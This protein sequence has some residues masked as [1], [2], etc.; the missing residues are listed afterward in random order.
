MRNAV[1]DP[2]CLKA[3]EDRGQITRG[4]R[5]L[6]LDPKCGIIKGRDQSTLLQGRRVRLKIVEDIWPISGCKSSS[7]LCRQA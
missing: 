5:A 3:I 1:D 4:K 7:E 6:V 2:I